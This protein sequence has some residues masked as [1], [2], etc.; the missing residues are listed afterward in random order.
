MS[1]FSTAF[2]LL[3]VLTIAVL[4]LRRRLPPKKVAGG[5]LNLKAFRYLPYSLY[6]G[7]SL[8]SFL[9]LYTGG[10][11][12]PIVGDDNSDLYGVG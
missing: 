5:L 9:G 3:F 11:W 2:I 6:V 10:L 1:T 12:P 4:T 7:A 8:V